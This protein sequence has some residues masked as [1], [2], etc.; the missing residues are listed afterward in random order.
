MKETN[1][2]GSVPFLR[3]GKEDIRVVSWE[4]KTSART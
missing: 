1:L 4:L 3:E 2:E